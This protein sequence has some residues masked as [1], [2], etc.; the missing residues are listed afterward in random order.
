M[1]CALVQPFS[2]VGVCR[3]EAQ[4]LVR[5]QVAGGHRD[6]RPVRPTHGG[7]RNRA[8]ITLRVPRC[9]DHHEAIVYE[10]PDASVQRL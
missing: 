3:A 5:H 4:V 9:N 2:G 8:G 1:S 10:A 6:R 7:R